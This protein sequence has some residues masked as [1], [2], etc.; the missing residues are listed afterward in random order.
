MM[1]PIFDES[2]IDKEDSDMVILLLRQNQKKTQLAMKNATKWGSKSS[3]GY[4]K[5]LT[6]SR[7]SK[8]LIDFSHI[9]FSRKH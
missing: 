7:S 3:V 5:R 4:L 8:K 6:K 2:I 1:I 9:E